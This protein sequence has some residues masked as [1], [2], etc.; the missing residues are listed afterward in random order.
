MILT[1]DIL[2]YIEEHK[3]EAFD[4]L[5]TLARIPAPS[6]N[7]ERRAEFCRAWLEEQGAE[8]VY[9]DEALNVI[10][11]VG[12]K[13]GEP[14]T[15]YMAHSDVVFPDTEPLPLEI[16]DG[17]IYCPGI[18]DDT[19]NVVALLTVAKYVAQNKL[20]PKNGGI[21]FVVNSCEE[22][23]GNL[24]G[25]RAIVSAFGERISEFISL[26]G[27]PDEI[28]N[29]AVGSKRYLIE[30]F[31]EGGHSYCHFGNRNAIAYMANLIT[32]LYAIEIPKMDGVKTT[33]NVG[34]IS[35]GTSVNTIAQY[36]KMLYE[37]RSSASDALE[38]MDKK[39]DGIIEHYRKMGIDVKVTIVGERPST[40]I[41]DKEREER[42]SLRAAEA[43]KRHFGNIP[44]YE[45]GSTD[46]NIPLSVGVP[47]ICFGG[48]MAVGA[49][50]REEYLD[51]TTLKLGMT[52]VAAFMMTYFN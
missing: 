22:G 31:T 10:Y 42:L 51:S 17:R 48:N 6:H 34:E 9:I 39:F 7:E 1:D 28:I 23:L 47:A 18:G 41:V 38:I 13:D 11:P 45:Y 5:L 43:I 2:K 46:C 44:P 29:G 16:R 35:G 27:Y 12:V 15:V 4:L 21:L 36:A 25:S 37:Y 32:D 50:T 8:G 20:T 3:D 26:D 49:H 33:F 40:G 19:A 52:V 14:L 30:I 24:K